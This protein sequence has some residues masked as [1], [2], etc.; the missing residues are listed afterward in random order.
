M[1][2]RRAA[3]EIGNR[4]ASRS[5]RSGRCSMS[6][7][8]QMR[9]GVRLG[10]E[11][12]VLGQRRL[13]L[14]REVL[15]HLDLDRDEHVAGIARFAHATALD[16]DRTAVRRSRGNAERPYVPGQGP[17][18]GQ[19]WRCRRHA[20]HG[21]GRGASAPLGAGEGGAGR[22]PAARGRAEP[23]SASDE[24]LTWSTCRTGWTATPP[25]SRSPRLR[26]WPA[27]TRRPSARTTGSVSSSPPARAAAASNTSVV[28]VGRGVLSA[29]GTILKDSLFAGG[30]PALVVA[31]ERTWAAAGHAVHD[32]L[33][34]AGV[35]VL[36]PM[37]FPGHPALY[38]A[39]ENC[40]IIRERLADSGALGVA[41]GSGTIN[42]LVKR[43]SGQL[44]QPY[45]VVGTAA[46]MDGYSGFGAPMSSEGVKVTMPCP[47]PLVV[48]IDL[49]VAAAAPPS[50]VA[51]GYGDLS[52]KIPAGADWILSDAVGLDPI[53]PLAWELVQSGVCLLYTSPSP[54]DRT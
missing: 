20:R 44:G 30:K 22:V 36:E 50:M 2:A 26:A 21:R 12:L 49:D 41:V 42:D 6:T 7:P 52:A 34:T 43:A 24:E 33:V 31:D 54:R 4:A 37:I 29:S 17:W 15:R 9:S 18:R 39:L 28:E 1:P 8:H 19:T 51:S 35:E 45:G 47:A 46:S 11:P 40:D 25:C 53:D 5:S 27:C 10:R 16:P 48:I 32:A 14:L 23:P 38:A 13:R 3:V